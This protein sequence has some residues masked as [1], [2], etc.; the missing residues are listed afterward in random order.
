MARISVADVRGAWVAYLAAAR[1]AGFDTEGW[2]L[3]MGN[4]NQGVAYRATMTGQRP[5]PGTIHDGMH[6]AHLGMTRSDAYTALRHAAS[7]LYAVTVLN[8]AE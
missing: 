6:N 3:H 8:S 4:G 7:A 5:A 1:S 2:T